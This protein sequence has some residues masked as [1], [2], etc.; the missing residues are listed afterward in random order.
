MEAT[1]STPT[2]TGRP[3]RR[4]VGPLLAFIVLAGSIVG[5]ATPAHAAGTMFSCFRT[6]ANGYRL[7]ALEVQIQA[8]RGAW[9]TVAKRVTD[10]NG[11]VLQPLPSPWSN[12]YL[13]FYVNTSLLNPT[14]AALPT[15]LYSAY[16]SEQIPY[17][18]PGNDFVNLGL[19]YVNC[20]FSC[21]G[22]GY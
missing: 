13:R 9:V 10:T 21:Y 2:T 18:R 12:E 16:S 5:T 20:S 3:R 6:A 22:V 15:L 14:S 8:W 19:H 1:H 4:L 7:P 11:C 17:T